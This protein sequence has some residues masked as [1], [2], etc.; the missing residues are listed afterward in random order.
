MSPKLKSLLQY[1]VI[2]GITVLLIYFS[3]AGLTVAEGEN[4][5][6]YLQRTWYAAD[7]G[8][9]VIMAVLAIISH[10]VRAER[11]R[12]L[13]APVGYHTS[14]SN[15]FYSLMVGYLVNLVIPRGGE[16][17][18]CYNLYK[19]DKIPVVESF[20]TVV[21]ERII[22]LLFLVILIV[23]SFAFESKKLFA[24]IETLPININLAGNSTAKAL[25]I[26]VP[27]LLIILILLW[28]FLKK[29]E[30]VRQVLQKTWNSFRQGILS[31]FKLENKGLFVLYSC[32]IWLLYFAMSYAVLK[33]FPATSK[34]DFT[35]VLSL[36]A[37]GAIAMA[38]PL[39]GGTGS[40]HVLVPQGLFFLYNIPLS[41][42]VAFTFIF[43]GWQTALFIIFG[44]VSLLVTSFIVKRKG[45]ARS[46]T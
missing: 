39:P 23:V 28:W 5:W 8:W 25:L 16:I 41:E 13:L 3:L 34:L 17:S 33:A 7:K 9:L 43:H 1:V 45:A 11:W 10:L 44:V 35:A 22:D 24:F 12:M 18:R 27:A 2:L 36:F 19:L 26:L 20:G 6:D 21:I 32:I 15:S 38:A 46:K 31:V 29:N 42:A 4:K 30:K 37:I 14:V 40:Y